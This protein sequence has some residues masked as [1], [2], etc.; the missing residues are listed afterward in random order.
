[1]D[2][3]N[4]HKDAQRLGKCGEILARKYLISEGYDILHQNWRSGYLEVDLIAKKK[5]CIIFAE[6]KTR[7]S[8]IE[9]IEEIIS[10]QKENNLIRALNI[11]MTN[12]DQE[13]LCRID[14]ILIEKKA[15]S[16]GIQHFQNAI[17]M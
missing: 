1:M 2:S 9:N 13:L 12:L 3:L 5:N 8:I 11:Y 14:V 6:V 10:K 7:E 17:S 4:K 15:D 16:M